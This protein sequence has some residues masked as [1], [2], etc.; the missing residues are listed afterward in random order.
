MKAQILKIAGVKSEKEFYKKFP[1]EA[2]FKKAHG[3]ELKKAQLG[4]SMTPEVGSYIGGDMDENSP[5]A[6]RELYDDID[7]SIT[8]TNTAERIQLA[9]LQ[10]QQQQA[11]AAQKQANKQGIMDAISA[12]MEI[13]TTPSD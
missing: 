10:A 9:N 5:L 7:L 11:Q 13:G 2:S 3:K 1:T 4:A 6:Y 8:G 12:G